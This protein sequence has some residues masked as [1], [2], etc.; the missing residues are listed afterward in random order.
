M[1]SK[2]SLLSIHLLLTGYFLFFGPFSINPWDG[3]DGKCYI[4]SAQK[5]CVTHHFFIRLL[6]SA[7][8]KPGI[9]LCQ[10]F[11]LR[12]ETV[13]GLT[14]AG[15][16][17]DL[18]VEK[19]GDENQVSEDVKHHCDNLRVGQIK[20]EKC[21]VKWK[22]ENQYQDNDYPFKSLIEIHTAQPADLNQ[23]GWVVCVHLNGQ[24]ASEIASSEAGQ[25]STEEED[26]KPKRHGLLHFSIP[27]GL[28]DLPGKTQQVRLKTN[29]R[30]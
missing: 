22:K 12:A 18:I 8:F 4:T 17:F 20:R 25:V 30:H 26:E 16:V 23:P 13:S 15:A 29:I 24:L 2:Q 1:Y 3:C 10:R 28:I 6:H 7:V 5:S 11:N 27:I 19:L 9:M 21:Q 14:S